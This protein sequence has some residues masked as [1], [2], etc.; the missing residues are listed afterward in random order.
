[1]KMGDEVVEQMDFKQCLK[2]ETEIGNVWIVSST[3]ETT[4]LPVEGRHNGPQYAAV[5]PAIDTG[6]TFC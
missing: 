1:M 5:A 4:I 3:P 2:F 6:G